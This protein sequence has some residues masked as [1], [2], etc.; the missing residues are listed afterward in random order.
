MWEFTDTEETVQF[1]DDEK[2]VDSFISILD[3]SI[4]DIIFKGNECLSFDIFPKERQELSEI[5]NG[6]KRLNDNLLT[7]LKNSVK[8]RVHINP[9]WMRT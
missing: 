3:K 6:M 5:V 2:N 4:H 8:D 9:S 7:W 1:S